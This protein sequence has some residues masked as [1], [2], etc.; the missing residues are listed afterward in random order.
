MLTFAYLAPLLLVILLLA[1]GRVGTVG[2]GAVGLVAAAAAAI[3]SPTGRLIGRGIGSLLPST[4]P[5]STRELLLAAWLAREGAVGLWLAWHV[6]VVVVGGIFLWRCLEA[7]HRR[8]PEPATPDLRV[9]ADPALLQRRLWFATFLLGPFTES[10]TGF[11]VGCIIA[12]AFILRLGLR[13]LPALLLA[14]FSQMLVPWGALAIGTVLGATLA[15]VPLPV[16]GYGSAVLQGPMLLLYLLLFWWLAALC[17][18]RSGPLQKLDDLA[19]TAALWAMLLLANRF[20]EV[21]IAG[22]SA[23]G[24][25]LVLR[26]LRDARPDRAAWSATL[27]RVWPY[28]LLVSLLLASRLVP[29]LQSFLRESLAIDA[30]GGTPVFS[31][32]YTPAS[33]LILVGAIVLMTAG[34]RGSAVIEALRTTARA[35]WRPVLVTVLFVIMA[36]IYGGSGMAVALASALHDGMGRAAILCSPL[37]AAVGGFLTAS[38]A[39]ANAMLMPL[40]AALAQ[41][42]GIDVPLLAVLQNSVGSNLT[43]LSPPRVALGL[44]M[45]AGSVGEAEVY[46]RGWVL[47]LPALTVGLGAAALLLV[48]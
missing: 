17:G 39:G 23:A 14:L 47:S 41:Q 43:M 34:S 6:L 32:L 48:T 15:V 3:V 1:S 42:A 21:E 33:F 44:A 22:A 28:V 5:S 10:V 24:V 40:Q 20:I 31:P 2:A 13:G 30:F 38:N 36:R 12:L 29:P 11:G 19:W 7:V 16:L 25:L 27:R 4:A 26:W 8:S 18:V 45:L 37:L 9:E 46:R 35:I